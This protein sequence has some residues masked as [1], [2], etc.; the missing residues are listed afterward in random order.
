MSVAKRASGFSV[1]SVFLPQRWSAESAHL[2]K[3]FRADFAVAL[4]ATYAFGS[5]GLQPIRFP[6]GLAMQGLP[7]ERERSSG[8]PSVPSSGLEM[9]LPNHPSIGGSSFPSHYRFSLSQAIKALCR[10]STHF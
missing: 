2:E 8:V 9:G 4:P 5:R 7:G 6:F 10:V 3:A 1:A